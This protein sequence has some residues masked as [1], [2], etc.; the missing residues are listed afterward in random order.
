MVYRN[1]S[2]KSRLARFEVTESTDFRK[3]VDIQDRIDGLKGMDQ[4]RL[5]ECPKQRKRLGVPAMKS[6]HWKVLNASITRVFQ[7]IEDIKDL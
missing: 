3:S 7:D 2:K 4:G 1:A 6:R 5:Q